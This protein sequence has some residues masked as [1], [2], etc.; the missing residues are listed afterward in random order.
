MDT[1]TITTWDVTTIEEAQ[2]ALGKV[3]DIVNYVSCF[4]HEGM[5]KDENIYKLWLKCSNAFVEVYRAREIA[6]NITAGVAIAE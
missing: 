6:Q 5:D 2:D 1:T 4:C 3:F